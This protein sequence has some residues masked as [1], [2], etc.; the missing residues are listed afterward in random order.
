MRTWWK[1]FIFILFYF[2]F[3]GIAKWLKFCLTNPPTVMYTTPLWV[4]EQSKMK[5][6]ASI[7]NDSLFLSSLGVMDYSLL[8]LN[9]YLM[10]ISVVWP[11]KWLLC[12]WTHYYYFFF[13]SFQINSNWTVGIQ[14][15]TNTIFVGIIDYLRKYTWDKQL[16]TWVKSSGIMG[17]RGKVP[18]VISPGQVW[19][20]DMLWLFWHLSFCSFFLSI[21]S[22][23]VKQWRSTLC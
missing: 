23:F 21:K 9:F 22:G 19:D 16:E 3:V 2:F 4:D 17:G 18:T 8:G 20:A 6:Q 1:V 14:A 12:C 5:L 7:W 13:L 10:R 15:G 11:N